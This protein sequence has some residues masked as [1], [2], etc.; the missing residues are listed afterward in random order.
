MRSSHSA[1]LRVGQHEFRL[2][3]PDLLWICVVGGIDLQAA[4]EGVRVMHT[5]AAE[6]RGFIASATSDAPIG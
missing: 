1:S 3:E 4:S 6:K 2:E 5:L